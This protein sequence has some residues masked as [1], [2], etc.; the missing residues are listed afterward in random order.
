MGEAA[1]FR[2]K[3]ALSAEARVAGFIRHAREDLAVFGGALDWAAPRWTLHG[4]ANVSG[5]DKPIRV[6]WG[7]P[8]NSSLRSAADYEPLDARNVDFFKAYLRYR[9]GFSMPMNPSQMLSAMRLLDKA[10]CRSGAAMVEARP[11]D[12][13]FAAAACRSDYAGE[14]AYRVGK[15]LEAIA[16]FLDEHGFVARPLVWA[17]PI[18]KPHAWDRIGRRAERRRA[19]K[20]P[21]ERAI[22][23]LGTA[24]RRARDPMDV[25]AVSAYALLLVTHSRISELHR[26]DAYDCEV[27]RIEHGQPRYGLRWYPSKGGQPETRWVPGA[28]VALAREALSR[29]R[30]VTEPARDLARRYKAGEPILPQEDP[31]DP[32][33]L[34][35][36]VSRH[37]LATVTDPD[38]FIDFMRRHRFDVRSHLARRLGIAVSTTTRLYSRASI[39]E[40]FRRQLPDGFPVADPKS[41]LEYDR[42]LLVRRADMSPRYRHIFWRLGIADSQQIVRT[43]NGHTGTARRPPGLFERLGLIDD[44]GRTV[45]ITPHQ[46]RHYMSTL[47]NEANLSQLDIAKWAGR[48]DVRHNAYYD[49]ET[50]ESLLAKAR[51]IDADM[52]GRA[53]TATPHRPVTAR[54]LIEGHVPGVHLTRYGACLHDFAMSPCPMYRDCLNCAE[55]ACVKGDGRAERSIRD[56][57]SVIETALGGAGEA[58]AAG[59]GNSRIWLSRMRTERARLRELLGLIDDP[60]IRPGAILRLSD[61]ARYEVESDASG[62]TPPLPGPGAGPD[63]VPRPPAP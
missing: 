40:A 4:V 61:A 58:A 11:D 38:A 50:A 3:R 55:H 17:S 33:A 10:L 62:A 49:H 7:H 54:Q 15:Q 2:P 63:P 6:N 20:L 18:R 41:G 23:A 47:A 42:A 37:S 22:A 46:L 34:D 52:F 59:E 39:E 29:I 45:R 14:T 24:Y 27:E 1:L 36:Y 19:R 16:R 5:H 44:D 31:H 21:S 28:F 30:D 43:M 8:L 32:L 26:L 60:A 56:R 13:N 9:Y 57:L 25:L 48:A 51:A 35:G 53:L 12:F